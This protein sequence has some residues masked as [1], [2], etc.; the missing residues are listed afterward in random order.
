MRTHKVL[1]R[2]SGRFYLRIVQGHGLNYQC[3]DWDLALTEAESRSM[4]VD[5]LK[6]F[7]FEDLPESDRQP[8]IDSVSDLIPVPQPNV[9]ITNGNPKTGRISLPGDPVYHSLTFRIPGSVNF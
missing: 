5:I 4:L 9:L 8:L 6:K 2:E 1:R 7:R 3:Y